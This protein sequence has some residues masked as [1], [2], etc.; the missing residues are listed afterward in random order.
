MAEYTFDLAWEQE[1]TRVA[2]GETL[3]DSFTTSV[4]DL[5]GVRGGWRC[6]EVGAGGGTVAEWLCERSAPGGSVLALDLDTRFVERV[7]QSNLE[8]RRHDIATGVPR[9]HQWDLIHGR[10][11]LEH[12][13][14]RSEVVSEMVEALAPGGWLVLEDVDLTEQ[15]Y[16]PPQAYFE[17]PP[18]QDQLIAR[19]TAALCGVLRDLGVNLD[20]GRKLPA[21]LLANGLEEVDA[22]YQTQLVHGGTPRADYT[23]LMFSFLRDEMISRGLI[24]EEEYEGVIEGHDDPEVAFMSVPLFSAWGRKPLG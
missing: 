8:V 2:A 7:D 22:R 12:V 4:F 17:Y 23:R 3:F 13:P 10:L 24:S 5:V 16:L 20:Y 1:R 18:R 19:G 21:E 9:D 14:D 6:L 15:P 11:V